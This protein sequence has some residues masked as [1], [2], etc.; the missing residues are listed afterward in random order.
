MHQELKPAIIVF[1][2]TIL[3]S[4]ARE[5]LEDRLRKSILDRREAGGDAAYALICRLAWH[6]A[7]AA[8]F[9]LAGVLT[10]TE[11]DL[12]LADP[13]AA[14]SILLEN[15]AGLVKLIEPRLLGHPRSVERLLVD[16]RIT[17]R[18]AL[19]TDTDYLNLLGDEPERR[20]RLAPEGERLALGAELKRQSEM[21]W[22][23]SPA[24]AYWYL[25]SHG[26]IQINSRLAEVLQQDEECQFRALSWA[27][28]L[29][30]PEEERALL[31]GFRTPAWAFHALRDQLLPDREE[32]LLRV[33]HAHPAWLAEWWHVAP[34]DRARLESSYMEAAERCAWHELL[35]ELYWFYRTTIAR[36]AVRETA[37]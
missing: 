20:V 14:C 32:E 21:R 1:P 29:A 22:S 15:Y 18:T 5:R 2:Q 25:V 24:M 11:Q 37:A 30:R 26:S 16:R 34:W 12:L 9:L 27:F 13:D 7:L 35:P 4:C 33:V 28:R 31:S 17:A 19:H 10:K 23:E 3:N 6:P 8:E 36:V